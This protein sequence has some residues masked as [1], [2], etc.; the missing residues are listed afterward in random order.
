MVDDPLAETMLHT[1]QRL[2]ARS[3]RH[4]PLAPLVR[5]PTLTFLAART[6]FF[7]HEVTA[8]L[9]QGMAQVVV[10]GAGY[11]SRAWRLARP[12]V[13]FY[14]VD[15]P[16]T[17][18]DKRACAP[19][20]GPTYVAADLERDCLQRCLPAAGFN[21]TE[22]AIFVVEG[23][24]MYLPED[25]VRTVLGNL[26]HLSPL[27]SRLAVNFTVRGGGS[28]SNPSRAIAWA[29]RVSAHVRGERTHGWVRPPALRALLSE[30][31]WNVREILS[32]PEL[33]ARYLT[34]SRVQPGGLNPGAICV[35]ADRATLA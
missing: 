23:L 11:D 27:G 18:H 29:L 1:P 32:G 26:A 33:A 10:V 7:D 22:R 6:R 19:P 16:A 4:R 17:Q 14:E 24:T 31:G 25:A 20:G 5:S 13:S 35:A 3:L 28:V 9:D 30:T 34:Q 12:G 2:L 21:A 8:A 15:H